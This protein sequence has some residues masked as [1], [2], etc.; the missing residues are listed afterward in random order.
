MT[1]PVVYCRFSDYMRRAGKPLSV[2]CFFLYVFIAYCMSPTSDYDYCIHLKGILKVSIINH[3][4][5]NVHVDFWQNLL[6][7]RGNATK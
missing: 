7:N 5:I 2:A 3:P 4:R 6:V 1:S